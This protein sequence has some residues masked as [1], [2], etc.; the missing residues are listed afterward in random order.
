VYGHIAARGSLLW[1]AQIYNTL[2]ILSPKYSLMTRVVVSS[3][4]TNVVSRTT[5][6]AGPYNGTSAASVRDDVANWVQAAFTVAD[7]YQ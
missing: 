1:A 4:N 7:S 2:N 6:V 5:T 3:K